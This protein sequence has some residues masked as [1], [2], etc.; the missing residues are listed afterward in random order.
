MQTI[1]K[2]NFIVEH[3]QTIIV[4]H[5]QT[6]VKNEFQ[7]KVKAYK[8]KGLEPDHLSEVHSIHLVITL[9]LCKKKSL[10]LVRTISSDVLCN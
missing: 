2:M 4:E 9:L 7:K 8:V 1:V 3:L 6:I 10:K 5:L